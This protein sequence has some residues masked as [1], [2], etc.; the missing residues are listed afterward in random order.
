MKLIKYGS[1]SYQKAL[2][3]TDFYE[4]EDSNGVMFLIAYNGKYKV[5]F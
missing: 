5:Y 3:E 4:H 1:K 2:L